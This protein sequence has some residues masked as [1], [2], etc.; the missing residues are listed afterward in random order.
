M[1]KGIKGTFTMLCHSNKNKS[2][3]RN[4]LYRK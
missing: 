2:E 3:N 1:R 4:K